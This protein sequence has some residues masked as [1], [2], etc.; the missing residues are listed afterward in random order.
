MR[1]PPPVVVPWEM[2][3]L[4]SAET[5]L[6]RLPDG[7]LC[8]GHPRDHVAWQVDVVEDVLRLDEGGFVHVNRR[9]GREV[10]R[11]EYTFERV[12][13]GTRYENRLIVG[14]ASGFGRWLMNDVLRPRVLFPDAKGRAWLRHNVE[15]VGNFQFFLPG[16]YESCHASRG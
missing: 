12:A 4:D 11:M 16:L 5:R 8:C 15:E 13:G 14:I 10:A 2:K 6:E 3:P 7:R 1:L 9:F